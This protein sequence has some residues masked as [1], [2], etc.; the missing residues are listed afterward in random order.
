MA[1]KLKNSGRPKTKKLVSPEQWLQDPG[2]HFLHGSCCLLKSYP[3]FDAPSTLFRDRVGGVRNEADVYS[4][5]IK[6]T[7]PRK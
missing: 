2:R 3:P 1:A 7:A 5:T 4:Q 6:I